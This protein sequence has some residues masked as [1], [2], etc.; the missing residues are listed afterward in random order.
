MTTRRKPGKVRKPQAAPGRKPAAS[1]VRA[2]ASKRGTSGKSR[3][4]ADATRASASAAVASFPADCT[5]AQAPEMKAGLAGMLTQ[6][7]CVT[8]DLSTIRRVDTAT[9]QLLTIFSR[10]RRAA[11]R[12]VD[13]K[14]AS[15]AFLVTA[16][17]LGLSALFAP[18]TDD[19]LAA[20]AA[21]NA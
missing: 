7:A 9:L 21:G 4:A 20:P 18:V 15:D 8:L 5:I 1:R 2:S 13:C 16:G 6:S 3:I 19:R 17:I 14:G 12:A 10:D 11:G